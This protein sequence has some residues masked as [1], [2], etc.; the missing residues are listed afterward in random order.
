MHKRPLLFFW[1]KYC[2]ESGLNCFNKES[3]DLFSER[4]FGFFRKEA[5]SL[6]P[7]LVSGSEFFYHWQNP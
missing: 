5:K 4:V 3:V 7:E 6:M 1:E 2:C